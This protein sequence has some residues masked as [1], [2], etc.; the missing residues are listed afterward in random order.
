[1]REVFSHRAG[2]FFLVV[3]V[4][5]VLGLFAVT[6]LFSKPIMIMGWISLPFAAGIVFIVI[7][8]CA[9]LIYFFRY[10]PFR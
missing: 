6:P 1:M 5:T 4:L 2:R 10:W 8:L 9:Y 7:W 3:L